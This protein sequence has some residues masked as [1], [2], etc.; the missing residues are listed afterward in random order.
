MDA[1][2]LLMLLLHPVASLFR[3]EK[4]VTITTKS[5]PYLT[6]VIKHIY[7]IGNIDNGTLDCEMT[8][9]VTYRWLSIS[10]EEISEGG[11]KLKYG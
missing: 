9:A 3:E 5:P 11:L 6:R 1:Y 2:I 10:K 8:G 7:Y 4:V